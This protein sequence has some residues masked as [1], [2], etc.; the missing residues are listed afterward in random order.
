MRRVQE[1]LS[2]EVES[3]PADEE[4]YT[5]PAA[6]ALESKRLTFA[7]LDGEA[8]KVDICLFISLFLFPGLDIYFHQLYAQQY[9]IK[10]SFI[11]RGN[12]MH[13]FSSSFFFIT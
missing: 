9:K 13:L 5:A 2:N 6:R 10:D 7:W 8:Q 1:T 3:V 11:L 4:P 12:I